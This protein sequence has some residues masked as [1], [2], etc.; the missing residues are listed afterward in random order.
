MDAPAKKI[1]KPW[2][3]FKTT[4]KDH[5]SVDTMVQEI[6][7]TDAMVPMTIEGL[8]RGFKRLSS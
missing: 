8:T 1:K 6:F 5:T 3:F 4:Q 7:G 2:I